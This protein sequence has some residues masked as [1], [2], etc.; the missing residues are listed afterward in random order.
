MTSDITL[1]PGVKGVFFQFY[2]VTDEKIHSN[3]NSLEGMGPILS[4][5]AHGSM[6]KA[7]S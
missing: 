6:N 1:P 5:S 2:E 3:E 7:F 4:L